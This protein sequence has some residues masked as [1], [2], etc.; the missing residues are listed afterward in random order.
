MSNKDY[1]SSNIKVLKGLEP[2]KQRP[3]MYTRTI[4]PNHMIGEVIDNAQD[5]ALAGFASKIEVFLNK[6]GSVIVRDNGRGIPVDPIEIEGNKPAVEVIFTVLHSGGKFDKNSGDSAYKFSGGLHGVG[7]C[8]TNALSHSVTVNVKKA[9]SLY[10]LGFENGYLSKPL[11]R[12]KSINK[13][14]TGTEVIIYPDM[15]YFEEQEINYKELYHYLR[16]KAILMPNVEVVLHKEG[17]EPIIW[18][19]ENGKRNYFMSEVEN[20]DLFIIEPLECNLSYEETTE[21]FS[22]GEG[23]DLIFGWTL[24][25]KPLKESFVNLI[26]TIA[27]GGH[28]LGLKNGLFNAIKSFMEHHDLTPKNLKIDSED[29]WNRLSFVLSLKMVDTQ[30]QGQ[31][32]DKLTSKQAP[33]LVSGLVKDYF[34]IYLNEHIENGKKI[35]EFI[36]EQATKRS[37][38]NAKIEK[39]KV[40]NGIVLPGKL[41]DCE[42]S[43]IDINELFLVEGDSA[44]GSGKQGRDRNYQAILP[45]RGK[46]LNTWEVNHERLYTSSTVSDISLAIGVEPHSYE[47]KDKIDLSKLRYGK[48]AILSD[49]DVDGSHI[50]VLLLTLF[51]KHFPKLIEDNRIFVAQPP[52]YRVDAP[53]AKK[54]KEDRKFYALNEDELE[55]IKKKLFKEGL[56]ESQIKVSRFKGLGE[57]NPDQLWDTTLNPETRRMLS[58]TFVDNDVE[59]TNLKFNMLM[60]DKN[61]HKRREW[62]EKEGNS[63]EADI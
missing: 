40:T 37:R 15:S 26:P 7:V 29:L 21:L 24:E 46:L 44:G 12:V 10:T 60:S 14:D 34:E 41:T 28:E 53:K 22:K 6:D 4:N 57:M 20:P 30:F 32:K 38:A 42:S 16:A 31:T 2:I 25:G 17:E 13:N 54:S 63:V 1:N 55:N 35:A 47:E 58:V 50:Q 62:M 59:D 39:R 11:E 27:G 19:Y 51:I 36:V 8:V 33:A 5:E 3:G 49:A 23:V 9:G 56:N 45:L 48:I 61:A 52:L 18:K 43:D